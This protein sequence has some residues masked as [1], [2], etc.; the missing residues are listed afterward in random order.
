M[1][2]FTSSSLIQIQP[3]CSSDGKSSRFESW[4]VACVKWAGISLHFLEDPEQALALVKALMLSS[5]QDPVGPP[6]SHNQGWGYQLKSQSRQIS[7]VHW[8]LGAN[9]SLGTWKISLGKCFLLVKKLVKP[10]WNGRSF[11]GHHTALLPPVPHKGWVKKE[12]HFPILVI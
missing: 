2:P 8:S 7:S 10:G 9:W 12:F 6:Q 5:L 1:E 4:F 3:T 11:W